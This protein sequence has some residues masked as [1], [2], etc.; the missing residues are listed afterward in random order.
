[1]NEEEE[2]MEEEEIGYQM[3]RDEYNKYTPIIGNLI[4][5]ELTA[6]CDT[7]HGNIF[8]GNKVVSLLELNPELNK[9]GKDRSFYYVYIPKPLVKS[10]PIE[11]GINRLRDEIYEHLLPVIK[12]IIETNKIEQ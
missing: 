11:E 7:L 1:M 9:K 12:S 2:Y 3:I 8:I 6:I 10:V 5:Y 4:K